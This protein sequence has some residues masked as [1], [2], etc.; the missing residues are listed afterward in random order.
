MERFVIQR[1]LTGEVM[2][3]DFRGI[4]GGPRKRQ[5]SAAGNMTLSVGAAQAN[6]VGPDGLPLFQEWATLITI[7]DDGQIP[8]RGIVTEV[9]YAGAEWKMTVFS[10]GT[11]I[12]GIPY[13]GDPY[14]GAEVDPASIV[15]K[16]V[17][18][19]QSFPDSDLGI[20]VVGSTPV[21]V[22]S[23]STQRRIEAVAYYEEKVA[24]YK[25]ENKTL[26]GLRKI[27]A[28]TRKTAAAQR[29]NRAAASRELT[30]TKK[31]L[32]AAK[33][34]LTAAKKTKDPARIAAA[35]NAV[36]AAQGNVDDLQAALNSRDGNID[37][38][39]ARIKA[40]QADVDAQAAIVATMKERKDKASELKSEA[41]Q[42]ESEDG[43]AYALE[44]WD[45]PDCG[46]LI[47][48]LAKD[49]PFDWVEEHYW[50]GDLPKTRIRIAYPRTG[51]RLSGDSDPT[52]VQG[53]NITVQLQPAAEGGD[54]ANTV[55]GI[56][57]GEGAG[58]IRRLISKRNGR[59]RRVATLQ[60]KDVKSKQDMVT[61]LQ[62][63]LNARQETLVVDSIVVSNHPNSPRGSY[64]LGDDINVRGNVPHYGPFELWHRIVGITEQPNGTTELDL[65]RSDSFTYGSGVEE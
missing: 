23:F 12:Y 59:I 15:R 53:V 50:S 34:S 17:A 44:W 19:V 25:A 63:E 1:A 45:G 6:T 13:E 14:Y 62:A 4:S 41:Q 35:Q 16:L 30:A 22:G 61:R 9:E 48:D 29:T 58:S 49:A 5:L 21:R 47:D 51:R 28:A 56:G 54:F 42:K 7:D 27:V 3:Y 24:D 10:M 46:R 55:F 11:S 8:F 39:S 31:A 32:T 64:S 36:T 40:Q 26:Q 57:A 52:F 43:G 37:A 18:Y 20:A 60:S 65:K 38:T 2:S 33:T